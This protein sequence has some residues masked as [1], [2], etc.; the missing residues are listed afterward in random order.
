[1]P[2]HHT[3]GG[4]FRNPWPDAEVRG[5]IDVLKWRLVDNRLHPPPPDPD[6]AVLPRAGNAPVL[7]EPAAPLAATW[8][9]HSTVLVEVGGKRVLTDP[10]WSDRVSPF[11]WTGPERWV[12]PPLRLEAL[13][14]LD[15]VVLSHNHYDHLDRP[16]VEWLARERPHLPWIVPLKLAATVRKF[17]VREVMELDWWQT[18]EVG[19][20][21]VTAVPAQHFSAR[22]LFD[23]GATLWCG[24]VLRVGERRV[25][26]AGDTGFHPE[27]AEI[28]RRLGPFDLALIPI[29]AYEP[30]WFMRTVHM[31]PE[32]AMMALNDVRS[33]HP[34]R[35]LPY[36]LPIHWGTYKLTDEPMDEPP[37]KFRQGWEAAGLDRERLWLLAHGERREG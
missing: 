10:V 15:L 33:A 26:F 2:Q 28:G 34:D 27:F 19:G 9:G 24:Y 12:P 29:G 13:P 30:R 11:S 18:V 7:P 32:D 5:W 31:N 16:S 14:A 6:P 1:M 35:P 8:L 4:R 3:P 25:Y 22:N 20:V 23:R 17:G 37:R 21:T 36:V